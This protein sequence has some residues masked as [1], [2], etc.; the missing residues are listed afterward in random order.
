MGEHICPISFEHVQKVLKPRK[1]WFL[2]NEAFQDQE[3]S[4]EKVS[5]GI[6]LD[7]FPTVGHVIRL[8]V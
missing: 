3:I 1:V 8:R 6:P 5:H 7:P 4:K 2:K